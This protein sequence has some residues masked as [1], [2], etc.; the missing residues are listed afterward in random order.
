LALAA[1]LCVSLFG[2]APVAAAA[3]PS[4]FEFYKTYA[5]T[6]AIIDAAVASAPDLARKL[7]IGQ[8]AEGRPIWAIEL[9]ADIAS[10]EQGKPEVV[11][12]GLTHARERASAEMA[13]Y[14]IKVLTN[15]YGV[16]TKLGRRVTRI[17]DSTV[18]WIIPML[19]PDGAEYDFSGGTFHDWSKNRQPTPGTSQIGTDIGRNFGF[20]WACCSASATDPASASYRGPSAWSAP[21]TRAWGEFIQS[22]EINGK[23][24]VTQSLSL[25]AGTRKVL[26]PMA[27]TSANLPEGMSADDRAAFK[28]L[29]KGIASRN[30]YK[31]M[32]RGDQAI[33]DGAPDDWAYYTQGVFALT[34][35]MA[36]GQNRRYYPSLKEL[37][38][39]LVRNRPAVL[40]FL[41][42]AGCPYR[43][44][45]LAEEHCA[46]AASAPVFAES[47][48]QSAA[49][50]AQ[51]AG[52]WCVVASARTWLRHIDQSIGAS[53]NELDMYMREADKNDWTDPSTSYY[54]RCTRGSP[55]PSFAHDG[56]GMAWT[57]YQYAT[58][59]GSLGF[60]DYLST[61]RSDMNW[62]IVRSIRS[63]GQPVG[64]IAAAG[65]HAILAVGY[66]TRLDPLSQGENSI[67]GM[68]V[69][70]PWYQAG[71]GNWSGWPSGGFAPNSY[72]AIN[73]WNDKYFKPDNN[74]GPYYAGKY[75]AILPASVAG[76]PSDN[77]VPSLGD[78]AWEAA[79][80]GPGEGAP[81]EGQSF[82]MA[83]GSDTAAGP[84][85]AADPTLAAA[86][87]NG[88]RANSLFN[89]P[90]LGNV[91]Q[92]YSL[93]R[94][95]N[96]ESVAGENPYHLVELVAGYRVRAVALVERTA[97]GY[98]FGELRPVT[99]LFHLP[100]FTEMRATLEAN[101]LEGTPRLVWDWTSERNPPFVPF[102]AG[103]DPSDGGLSII[104]R[105]GVL[106]R[107]EFLQRVRADN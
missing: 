63:S 81:P 11:I 14:M 36:K 42:Q 25:H 44:A 102:L 52:C 69:W 75:V 99:G 18:V 15:N 94:T 66:S 30:N 95:V 46:Q 79:R 100:S 32:Q 107:S 5:E 21:E 33:N 92:G 88:M 65:L 103:R 51:Q 98:Q 59:D 37:N 56:R 12:D 27:Y 35:D 1:S 62:Q 61:S 4:G 97:D 8:S 48:Y 77:P 24:H 91:P 60:N 43:A 31:K 74:E 41:E 28:A 13:V 80:A 10:G 106:D 9:T 45:G 93:G 82:A 71:F 72:V 76:P 34:L 70:D 19:N 84:T 87:E 86:V 2:G 68:R 22:R 49:A 73:T 89:D 29:A 57:M 16:D 101:N 7:S 96:V 58:P 50:Q 83:S 90:S 47:V 54:I 38:T 20:K 17:L 26:F 78:A 6:E 40:W 55:S 67:L 23:Q 39:D 85:L 3:E 53:Q 64:V 105:L 104:T